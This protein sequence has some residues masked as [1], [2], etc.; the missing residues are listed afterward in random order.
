MTSDFTG[1]TLG[2]YRLDALIGR[3]G[4]AAVYRGYQESIDRTVAVKVLPPEFLHDSTFAARFQT[5]ARLLA[6]L[7][8]PAILPLYDFGSVSGVTYIVMPFMAG[9]SLADRL[10]A[11][12]RLPLAEVIHILT[13]I[14]SALDYAHKQGVLHRDVKPSNILFDGNDAPFLGDFG[15]AKMM[16]KPSGLT[17]T[18]YVGTPIYMS[19]EQARGEPVDS[20]A[21]IYSLGVVV[22]RALSGRHVFDENDSAVSLMLKH[23]VEPPA[24]LREALP[25][26]PKSVD[27][28]VQK[29]LAKYPADRFQTA[30][31]FAA[32]LAWAANITTD[33]PTIQESR[34]LSQATAPTNILA[35]TPPPPPTPPPPTWTPPQP[36]TPPV[37]PLPPT[38]IP[39]T[40][41]GSRGGKG[42]WLLGGGIGVIAGIGV[43]VLGLCAAISFCAFYFATRATPTPIPTRTAAATATEEAITSPY[44]YEDDF[45]DP[46]SGWEISTDPAANLGYAEGEYAFNVFETGWFIWSNPQKASYSNIKIEV[47]AKD[48]ARTPDILFGVICNFQDNQHFYYLGIDTNGNYAIGKNDGENDIFLSGGGQ[49]AASD[50]IARGSGWYR[51]EAD[52]TG[53]GLLTLYVDGLLIDSVSDTSYADGNIGMF[54][55]VFAPPDGDLHQPKSFEVRFDDIRVTALP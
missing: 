54:V 42:G 22:Y 37:T 19:P 10:S 12:G 48:A 2:S 53:E 5:E 16:E 38:S 6:K 40:P 41:T 18:G 7:T 31:E 34:P 45:S 3:G 11:Q 50:K 9:G 21:D 30:T 25:D 49:I 46:A 36:V 28:V 32:A 26:L 29:A 14:A 8:H 1:H 39:A 17:G 15:I 23:A 44:L 4:M 43:V 52:C 13:P 20:R 35:A 24:S 27:D 51:I 33:A 47:Q 55:D